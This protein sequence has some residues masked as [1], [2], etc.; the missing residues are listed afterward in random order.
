[1]EWVV[2]TGRCGLHNYTAMKG[3]FIRSRIE[4]KRNIVKRYHGEKWDAR[5]V[6]NTCQ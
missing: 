2:G 5:A 3:G 1:M 6:Q 4:W